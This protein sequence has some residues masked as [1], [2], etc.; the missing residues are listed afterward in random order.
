MPSGL[1]KRQSIS[2]SAKI[3]PAVQK[4]FAL[5][6]EPAVQSAV[7]INLR[8]GGSACGST[9]EPRGSNAVRLKGNISFKMLNNSRKSKV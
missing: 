9:V 6:F 3:E 1:P 8:T 5:N 7:Q 2:G 4:R